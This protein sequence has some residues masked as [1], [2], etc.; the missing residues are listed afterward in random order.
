M[1]KILNVFAY[2]EESV[3]KKNELD[4]LYRKRKVLGPSLGKTRK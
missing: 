2:K 4:I 3:F 1:G